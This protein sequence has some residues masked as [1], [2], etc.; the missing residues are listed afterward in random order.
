MVHVARDALVGQLAGAIAGM[1]Q[2]LRVFWDKLAGQLVHL[3]WALT[4]TIQ[5]EKVASAF[6]SGE[7]QQFSTY[8][9]DA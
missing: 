7:F 2:G 8:L 9:A 4:Y 6:D 1:V 3:D 5:V